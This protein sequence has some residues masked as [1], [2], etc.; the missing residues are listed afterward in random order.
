MTFR[1]GSGRQ[2]PEVLEARRAA[3]AA[4]SDPTGQQRLGLVLAAEAGYAAALAPL[5]RATWLS[6]GSADPLINLGILLLELKRPG[7][8]GLSFRRALGLAPGDPDVLHGVGVAD[9]G[10][11]V[12]ESAERHLRRSLQAQAG[13][14][15]TIAKLAGVLVRLRQVEKAEPLARQV[16]AL[17]PGMASGHVDRSAV[18]ARQDRLV[19]AH[20][21]CLRALAIEPDDAQALTN[22]GGMLAA[23]GQTAASVAM[24][25]RAADAG[26][27]GPFRNML[28]VMC[29][30]VVDQATRWA[31]A[32]EF[33]RRYAPVRRMVEFP[34]SPDPGRRLTV[35]YL[36][37]D[38]Y[39]HPVAR[40]LVPVL[41]AHDRSGLRSICYS[42]A[43]RNDSM[44]RRLQAAADSWRPTIGLSDAEVARAVRGDAV[45]LLVILAG[46]LDRNR[47]LVAAERAAPVQVS[48]FDVGTSGLDDMDYLL[49]DRTL[50]PPPAGR[51]EKFIERVIRLPSLYVHGP[52]D[53]AAD[54][55][56]PPS[57]GSGYVT[58]GC[59]NSPLKLSDETLELWSRLLRRLPRSRLRLKFLQRYR[60]TDLRQRVLGG[61][62]VDQ[63]R[64]DFLCED[65]P[66]QV[67][68]AN[69]RGVDI[70]L[71]TFPFTGCT[72]T[73]EA[74]W[75]GVPVV[76]LLGDTLVGRLTA[77]FLRPAGLDGLVA[78]TPEAYVDIAAALAEDPARL[79]SLRATLRDRLIDSPICDGPARARQFERVYRAVWRR[80]CRG[81]GAA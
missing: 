51:R 27:P 20:L 62:G 45:D 16:L 81:R 75:M 23:L 72:T 31:E 50:V 43:E 29:N 9:T 26:G 46:R 33:A 55:G 28:G 1:M 34:N 65:E 11:G 12:L 56:D 53:G 3:A 71:D 24:L 30:M 79:A 39:D 68:L 41:E 36:S 76:S 25:R 14:V 4:P 59:F 49:A 57:L 6:G 10:A 18:L 70:A 60:S 77:T 32:R 63:D 5:R 58:F 66:I 48:L 54:V 38:F 61:L 15:E 73:F 37:S 74:L 19:P 17:S 13:R 78:R 21:N 69:Y 8:A 7:E 42:D 35:G 44:S 47:P 80:W 64:V 2:T 52:I 67:H 40:N 22:A